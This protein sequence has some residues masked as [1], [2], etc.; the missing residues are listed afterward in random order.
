MGNSAVSKIIGIGDIWLETNLGY[1]LLFINVRHV[2]N[3]L[4]NLISTG[5][6]DDERFIS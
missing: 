2:P 6:V 1:N 3:M 4:L 5:K